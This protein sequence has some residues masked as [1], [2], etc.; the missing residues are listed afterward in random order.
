MPNMCEVAGLIAESLVLQKELSG[1]LEQEQAKA[2]MQA[3][4]HDLTDRCWNTCVSAV[5]LSRVLRHETNV[6][7][8]TL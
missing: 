3:S 8:S 4:I 5:S 6:S 2:K 7:R 1:F